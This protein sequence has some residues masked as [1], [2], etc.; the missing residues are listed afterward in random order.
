M[1]R[2]ANYSRKLGLDDEL[3]R[4]S[5]S[6]CTE[7]NERFWA[8]K[9]T[10]FAGVQLTDNNFA[11]IPAENS[12]S[13]NDSEYRN[14][15]GAASLLA[16]RGRRPPSDATTAIFPGRRVLRSGRPYRTDFV[17]QWLAANTSFAG[18][19][20]QPPEPVT[21]LPQSVRSTTGQA[22]EK[23]K[24]PPAME[25]KLE[26][27]DDAALDVEMDEDCK[28]DHAVQDVLSRAQDKARTADQSVASAPAPQKSDD[29]SL[30][31]ANNYC[32]TCKQIQVKMNLIFG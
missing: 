9:D 16:N 14:E 5:G 10:G 19:K 30:E 2:N 24:L 17:P 27:A 4:P 21:S 6:N 29:A 1:M 15:S 23:G 13:L 8:A 28:D 26:V 31:V 12:M 7:G 18:L 20:G 11:A 3:G 25:V 22:E 32:V